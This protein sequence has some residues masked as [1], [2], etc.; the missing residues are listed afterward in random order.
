MQTYFDS[1]HILHRMMNVFSANRVLCLMAEKDLMWLGKKRNDEIPALITCLALALFHRAKRSPT[2]WIE[3]DTLPK[4]V[5]FFSVDTSDSIAGGWAN[6][7]EIR[8]SVI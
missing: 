5:I 2:R 3:L 7:S 1:S 4:D 8:R 6:W